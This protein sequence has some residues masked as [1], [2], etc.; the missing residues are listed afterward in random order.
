MAVDYRDLGGR[1]RAK[2]EEKG[3]SQAELAGKAQLSTQHISNVEN[4]RS[5]VGLEKLV[6]IANILNC[7]LDELVCGSLRR[8]RT[9]Y[10]SEIA[11]IIEDFSDTEL[12][13]L[14]EFLKHMK[15]VYNLMESDIRKENES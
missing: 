11:E 6:D 7:S 5:K 4:A 15:Y 3:M 8:G 12:R 14:P 13:V 2:R 9:V 10:N 1:I